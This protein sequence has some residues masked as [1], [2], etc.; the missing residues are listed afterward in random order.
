MSAALNQRL[1][2]HLHDH[3]YLRGAPQ[4]FVPI[5]SHSG[6]PKWSLQVS[7]EFRFFWSLES[8]FKYSADEALEIYFY[9]QAWSGCSALC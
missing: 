1:M 6:R 5:V 2:R 8:R 4:F 9:S 7:L 3:G